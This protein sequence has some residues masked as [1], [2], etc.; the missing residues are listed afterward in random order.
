MPQ[1][2]M[3]PATTIREARLADLPE[4]SRLTITVFK[5]TVAPLFEPEGIRNFLAYAALDAWTERHR[6][7]QRTWLALKGQRVVGV[8]QVR[9]GS[10][11]SLFF[12]E[13]RQQR[14][15]IGRA[16]I[17]TAIK[18]LGVNRLTVN[19]SP[20][21]VDAYRRLG[22]KPVG[23]EDTKSGIRYTPMESIIAA[24]PTSVARLKTGRR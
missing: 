14:Q 12:I 13:R 4:A 22:F 11:V 7:G 9:D 10:H 8:V 5:Q 3:E 23:L 19:S 24:P 21:S 2:E 1:R 18:A 15:G 17:M 6:N 20:N 16:L